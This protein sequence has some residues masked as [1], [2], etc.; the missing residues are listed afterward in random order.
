MGLRRM[1]R[2]NFKF[3]TRIRVGAI[4]R[5]REVRKINWIESWDFISVFDVLARHPR[6]N[7]LETFRDRIKST[8]QRIAPDR[9]FQSHWSRGK[10]CGS[11]N[12]CV[13]RELYG[14]GQGN[15]VLARRKEPGGGW[16]WRGREAGSSYASEGL[17]IGH[18]NCPASH[19]LSFLTL[20]RTYP[21]VI[22]LYLPT[23]P[24]NLAEGRTEFTRNLSEFDFCM[25]PCILSGL[26]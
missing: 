26:C 13:G 11:K 6:G 5:G 25:E 19:G 12:E 18:S 15:K 2:N 4:G 3:V 21:P 23:S 17:G 10:N 16:W 14:V 8:V 7:A 20:K 1:F 22:L 24:V 9:I